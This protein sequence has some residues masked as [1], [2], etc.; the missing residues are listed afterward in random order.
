[1]NINL[2]IPIISIFECNGYI[3]NDFPGIPSIV[4][5]EVRYING[6]PNFFRNVLLF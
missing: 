3:F 2:S 4:K 1:M 6:M 5:Q